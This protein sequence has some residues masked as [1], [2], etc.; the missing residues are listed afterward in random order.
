M[1]RVNLVELGSCEDSDYDL[2]VLA[3]S[4]ILDKRI[5]RKLVNIT[6]GEGCVGVYSMR[7]GEAGTRSSEESDADID[8][9]VHF[10]EAIKLYNIR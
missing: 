6:S 10:G 4:E 1:E 3:D 7:V 9:G 5:V 2:A 8:E